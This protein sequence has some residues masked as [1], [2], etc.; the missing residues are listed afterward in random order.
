LR[1]EIQS[2]AGYNF[3]CSMTKVQTQIEGKYI[4]EGK[5]LTGNSKTLLIKESFSK[6]Y[7]RLLD[8]TPQ[9]NKTGSAEYISG[10]FKRN[11]TPYTD[12]F[13]LDYGEHYYILKVENNTALIVKKGQKGKGSKKGSGQIVVNNNSNL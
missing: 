9:E 12:V 5:K 10:L 8:I 13:S 7:L 1:V 4:L 3:S 2:L 6:P 11:S